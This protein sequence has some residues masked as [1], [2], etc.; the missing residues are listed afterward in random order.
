MRALYL[1]VGAVSSGDYWATQ[2]SSLSPLFDSDNHYDVTVQGMFPS[3]L[4]TLSV[5]GRTNV[6]FPGFFSSLALS[7]GSALPALT[8][9]DLSGTSVYDLSPVPATVTSLNVMEGLIDGLGYEYSYLVND[10]RD[11][12]SIPS[13]VT[14]LTIGYTV[15]S[16]LDFIDNLPTLVS[17][18]LMYC[19]IYDLSKLSQVKDTLA[20][21][22]AS[23]SEIYC[24]LDVLAELTNLKYLDLS[25]STTELSDYPDLSS[26]TSLTHLDLHEFEGELYWSVS[27]LSSLSNVEYLDLHD[28]YVGSFSSSC[29]SNIGNMKFLDIYE[30]GDTSISYSFLG[31]A[32]S[33][34]SLTFG[35]W[36]YDCNDIPDMSNLPN[37]QQLTM[38]CDTIDDSD[39]Q[40]IAQLSNLES[41]TLSSDSTISS[42][43]PLYHLSSLKTLNMGNIYTP[44]NI[45][46]P[47][48]PSLEYLS[49][50]NSS[51]SIVP[52]LSTVPKLRVFSWNDSSISDFS[53]LSTA[54]ALQS[55]VFSNCSLSDATQLSSVLSSLISLTDLTIYVS[56]PASSTFSMGSVTSLKYLNID[57][58][59]VTWND[60][61]EAILPPNVREC[62]LDSLE[63]TTPPDLSSLTSL[64]VLDLG[65]NSLSD[66]SFLSAESCPSCSSLKKLHLHYNSI[67]DIS[68]LS[69]MTSLEWLSL[70]DN[71]IS[72]ISPL[73][74]LQ[75]LKYL[76]ASSNDLSNVDLTPLSS[77]SSL[78]SLLLSGTAITDISSISTLVSLKYLDIS[79]NDISDVSPLFDLSNL[80][81][82][83]MSSNNL[84]FGNED[85]DDLIELF[86]SDN[87][88]IDSSD[89]TCNCP[90]LDPDSDSTIAAISK[91]L[92]CSETAP[93]SDTWNV[94]CMSDSYYT[95]FDSDTFTCTR[96][97]DCSGG[98]EYGSECRVNSDGTHGC[99]SVVPDVGLHGCVSDLIDAA[100]KVS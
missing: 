90:S 12:G 6:T 72:D 46:I 57:G 78:N 34:E 91:R 27:W 11:L 87:I 24:S 100:D 49:I 17:L 94:T 63:I 26:L 33:L 56:T 41:L 92:V 62:V 68:P 45:S 75:H 15:I 48:L 69:G 55:I 71:S 53:N 10:S 59:G 95:Y 39:L 65:G 97:A 23:H 98:C 18:D 83:D 2:L 21:F 81:L 30:V 88:S 96:S 84:C 1:T 77:L 20:H 9:L 16:D 4:T 19:Y 7:D 74:Y 51:S 86:E 66:I 47:S 44:S 37:L 13:T 85:E 3:S 22:S 76:S 82:L 35:W 67:E 54:S 64:Q 60:M 31:D 80:Y 61:S 42:I 40:N 28:A 8:T 36:Y 93:S 73:S 89:Q 58:I 99:A 50:P 43:S 52:D 70:R 5:S 32:S 14:E 25:Y 38:K 29:L 79:R